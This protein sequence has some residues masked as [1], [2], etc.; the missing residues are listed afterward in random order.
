MDLG[1]QNALWSYKEWR[2]EAFLRWEA[3]GFL[4]LGV[5]EVLLFEFSNMAIDIAGSQR[6][7]NIGIIHLSP[8]L[9]M[10]SECLISIC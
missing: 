2:L 9:L 7:Q 5:T 8:T 6:L 4:L 10:T 1:E 3:S